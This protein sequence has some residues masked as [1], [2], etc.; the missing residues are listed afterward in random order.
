AY[1]TDA[2]GNRS[3]PSDRRLLLAS[4]MALL[5]QR[6]ADSQHHGYV[7]SLSSQQPLADAQV[8]LVGRNGDTLFNRVTDASGHVAFPTVSDYRNDREPVAWLVR[9][10]NDL[11]FMPYSRHDHRINYSRFDTGGI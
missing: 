11:A 6:Q 10:G 2:P 7:M 3:G 5:T 1:G 8:S 4:D 9:R